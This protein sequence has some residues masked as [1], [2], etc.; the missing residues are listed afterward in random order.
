MTAD[1]YE[2]IT[3]VVERVAAFGGFGAV[4]GATAAAFRKSYRDDPEVLYGEWAAYCGAVAGIFGLVW[5][6]VRMG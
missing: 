2:R 5:T 4:V 6:L 1:L 3:T